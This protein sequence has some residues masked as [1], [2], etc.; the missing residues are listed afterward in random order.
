MGGGGG[1]GR[2]RDGL[3]KGGGGGGGGG[4]RK[5]GEMCWRKWGVVWIELFR[6]F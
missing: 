5:E 1:E 3:G 4:G 6:L 2:A